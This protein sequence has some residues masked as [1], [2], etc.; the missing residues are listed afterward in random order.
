V[1]NTKSGQDH[2]NP[3][4]ASE[5]KALPASCQTEPAEQELAVESQQRPAVARRPKLKTFSRVVA[6]SGVAIGSERECS[7]VRS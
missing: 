1:D 4:F 3:G 5:L 6:G 2:K 7:Q